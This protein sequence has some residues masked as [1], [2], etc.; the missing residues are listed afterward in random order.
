MRCVRREDGARRASDGGK[1]D[2]GVAVSAGAGVGG[3]GTAGLGRELGRGGTV[4]GKGDVLGL[5]GGGA[6]LG[7]TSEGDVL[8]LAGG[9]GLLGQD[10][11]VPVPD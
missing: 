8:G 10:L 9:G 1:E 5:A 6:V 4:D 11:L 3:G 2:E 7:L